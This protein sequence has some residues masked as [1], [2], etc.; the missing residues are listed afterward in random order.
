MKLFTCL[1]HADPRKLPELT[2]V[3]KMQAKLFDEVHVC[4][5]TNITDNEKLEAIR[6]CAPVQ[7]HQ[8][9]LEIFNEGCDQLPSP[10]LLTWVHK[11]LM[12]QRFHDPSFTHFMCIEDDM[13]VT[14]LNI[15]YWLDNREKLKP[16]NL[17]PSFLRVEWNHAHQQWAMTDSIK[18]DQFSVSKWPKLELEDGYAYINLGRTYQGMFLYD[19]ELMQEHINSVSFDMFKFIPDWQVRILRTDWPL[20]LTEAAV[21][22]LTNINVP[23]GYISRNIIPFYT[24]YLTIDPSCFVH[25]LPDKY[26]NMPNQAHGQV[27]IRDV[28]CK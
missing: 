2:Q 3:L 15:K 9:Q 28:L 1:A 27:L 24:K 16:F 12:L 6:A 26:T 8:F 10:W 5:I 17:Y 14:P 7:N 20:G 23:P 25:H 4:I 18:D 13:E 21:L 11:K 19:R 22:G